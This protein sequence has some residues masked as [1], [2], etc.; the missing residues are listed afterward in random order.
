MR[1]RLVLVACACGLTYLLDDALAQVAVERNAAGAL[2]S[3]AGASVDALLV[4]LAFFLARLGFVLSVTLGAAWLTGH[5]VGRVIHR[6]G[7][8][9]KNR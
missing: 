3:P 9:R 5:A 8:P 4:A 7:P 1:A 2:L 6:F